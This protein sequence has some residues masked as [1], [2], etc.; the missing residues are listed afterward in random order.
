M[1]LVGLQ[2]LSAWSFARSAGHCLQYCWCLMYKVGF[3]DVGDYFMERCAP[4]IH[5]GRS[6]EEHV[7]AAVVHCVFLSQ[8]Q[9][10]IIETYTYLYHCVIF[11]SPATSSTTTNG[12]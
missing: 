5:V 2:T 6:R 7:V 4:H 8:R 11:F 10:A 3:I 12:N 1:V 9:Q